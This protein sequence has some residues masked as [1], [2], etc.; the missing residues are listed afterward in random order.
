MVT[1]IAGGADILTGIP[2]ME[3]VAVT[4]EGHE[5]ASSLRA[6][7]ETAS[8]PY[9]VASGVAHARPS[10]VVVDQASGSVYGY[11]SR[12]AVGLPV[13]VIGV[14]LRNL[15][16]VGDIHVRALTLIDDRFGTHQ[17][18]TLDPAYRS[19]SRGTPKVYELVNARPRVALAH[20]FRPQLTTDA[21]Q[22]ARILAH[23]AIV[24]P[25][26]AG[27]SASALASE[28]PDLVDRVEVRTQSPE[29]IAMSVDSSALAWLAVADLYYPGWQALVDGTPAAVVRAN[30]LTR[31]VLVP[32]GRHE[33]E[34]T[35]RPDSYQSGF[36]A[37][38]RCLA[39]IASAISLALLA[40]VV[41]MV[42]D[43][44]L[45]SRNVSNQDQA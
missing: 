45:T 23:D 7:I 40:H 19:V 15:L 11:L 25:E 4:A 27:I 17:A 39:I 12:S 38:R 21:I 34:L 2:V 13:P 18:V 32:A 16:T 37:T 3:T 20:D 9:D 10:G 33:I 1:Y 44:I 8:E 28:R 22:E 26:V 36:E 5:I 41:R 6:G 31:A 42:R 43:R 35:Y 14:R 29:R 24:V 30:G